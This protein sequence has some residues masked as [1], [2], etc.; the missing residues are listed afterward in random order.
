MPGAII[1]RVRD[2]FNVIVA[3]LR[4]ETLD[5]LAVVPMKHQVLGALDQRGRIEIPEMNLPKRHLLKRRFL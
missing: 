1:E 2:R 3:I 4:D 5:P